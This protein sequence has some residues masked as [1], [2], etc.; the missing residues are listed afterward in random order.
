MKAF[1]LL[2]AAA[3]ALAVVITAA[4]LAGCAVSASDEQKEQLPPRPDTSMTDAGEGPGYPEV[5]IIGVTLPEEYGDGYLDCEAAFWIVNHLRELEGLEPLGRCDAV[6]QQA[7]LERLYEITS[8][9]SHTRPNGEKYSTVFAEHNITYVHSNENLACGQYTAEHVMHDW[10]CSDTHMANLLDPDID[11]VCIACC[12]DREGIPYWVFEGV[13]Y[14]PSYQM[15]VE[16]EYV[17]ASPSDSGTPEIDQ[18]IT[19]IDSD[20]Q[21]GLDTSVSRDGVSASD[22]Q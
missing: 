6:F 15:T 8:L 10:L 1:R 7:S 16:V 12:L 20:R 21:V 17:T 22:A 2:R 18:S 11:R 4:V 9:F 14:D 5:H 13:K 3:A 19:I